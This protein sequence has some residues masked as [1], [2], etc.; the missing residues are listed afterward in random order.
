MNRLREALRVVGITFGAALGM[1]ALMFAMVWA[2]P[3]DWPGESRDICRPAGE[4]LIVDLYYDNKVSRGQWFASPLTATEAD[5]KC[6]QLYGTGFEWYPLGGLRLA[7]EE[8]KT[9][10]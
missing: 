1:V 7:T 4:P 10:K 6:E 5:A 9:S 3:M 2:L 8:T